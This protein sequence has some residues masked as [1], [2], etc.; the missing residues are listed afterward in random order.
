MRLVPPPHPG[1]ILATMRGSQTPICSTREEVLLEICG[2]AFSIAKDRLAT[3]LHT[4]R[5]VSGFSL[6]AS[7]AVVAAGQQGESTSRS[8]TTSPQTELT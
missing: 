7:S 5:A 2:Q 4:M 3:I 1:P 8:T 6:L